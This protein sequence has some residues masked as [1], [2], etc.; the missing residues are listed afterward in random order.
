MGQEREA[1]RTSAA[2][3]ALSQVLTSKH[4]VGDIFQEAIET[5]PSLV[6]CSAVGAYI[7]DPETGNFRLARMVAVDASIGATAGGDR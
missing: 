3:L 7:R 2:L 4:D 1:A 5:I 6:A